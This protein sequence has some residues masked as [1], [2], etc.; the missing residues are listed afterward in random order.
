MKLDTTLKVRLSNEDLATIQAAAEKERLSV[1]AYIR[2]TA[3][4]A[5]KATANQEVLCEPRY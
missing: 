4:K 3:T 2:S 5:A 1:S